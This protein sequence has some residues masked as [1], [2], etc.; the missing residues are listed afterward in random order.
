MSNPKGKAATGTGKK[1]VRVKRTKTRKLGPKDKKI[2]R[3][4]R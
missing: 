2:K 4:E 1:K 3:K